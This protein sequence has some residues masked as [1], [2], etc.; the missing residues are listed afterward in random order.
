LPLL[1]ASCRVLG[2]LQH[3][4]AYTPDECARSRLDQLSSAL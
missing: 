2:I 1:L 3:S 4:P